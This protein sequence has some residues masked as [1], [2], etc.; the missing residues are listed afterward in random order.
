MNFIHIYL[1]SAERTYMRSELFGDVMDPLKPLIDRGFEATNLVQV[2]DTGWTIAGMT[3]SHCGVPLSPAGFSYANKFWRLSGFLPSAVCL[4]DVLPNEGYDLTFLAGVD[5]VFSGLSNFYNMHGFQ[6]VMGAEYFL[7][8]L[9]GTDNL[10]RHKNAWG[11]SD[12]LVF[13]KALEILQ[14]NVQAGQRFG[15]TIETIGGHSPIG[16]V[17]P[18]CESMERIMQARVTMLKA[19]KCTNWLLADFIS[20]SQKLGL[21]E[22]TVIIVQSD[23]FAMKNSVYSELQSSERRNLFFV[24]GPGIEPGKTDKLGSLMDVYPTVL[25]AIGLPLKNSRA[26]LGV[27]LLSE[28]TTL[29]ETLGEDAMNESI[30]LNYELRERLWSYPSN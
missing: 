2:R 30:A 9:E 19:V 7:Q 5:L 24:F 10:E 20:K 17:S 21:L 11:V 25:E 27:S 22:D 18:K 8:K 4:G 3:A 15:L 12:E 14:Q 13:D 26:G 29:V 16:L 28:E 1:E 6:Q 23:H